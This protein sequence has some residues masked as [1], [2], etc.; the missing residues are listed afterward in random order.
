MSILIDYECLKD[1]R[2]SL[3]RR[4]SHKLWPPALLWRDHFMIKN[5]DSKSLDHVLELCSGVSISYLKLNY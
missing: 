1:H 2:I 5:Y 4:Y 3:N